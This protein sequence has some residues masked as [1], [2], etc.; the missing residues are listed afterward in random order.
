VCADH[1]KSADLPSAGS[2]LQSEGTGGAVLGRVGN[3]SSDVR[4][5]VYSVHYHS[6][7]ACD[8]GILPCGGDPRMNLRP[9]L[10]G[11]THVAG[12]RLAARNGAKGGQ[13]AGLN[14]R[15]ELCNSRSNVVSF[16]AARIAT[17]T[18]RNSVVPDRAR[19]AV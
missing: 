19:L 7:D 15:V 5:C 1:W 18:S 10:F 2:V 3:V 6:I 16:G 17:L 8:H 14:G 4:Y 12:V 9:R 11:V 13:I